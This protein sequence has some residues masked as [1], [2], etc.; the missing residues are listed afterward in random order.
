MNKILGHSLEFIEPTRLDERQAR[1]A[2]VVARVLS[3]ALS[4]GVQAGE[5]WGREVANRGKPKMNDDHDDEMET[6]G[7]TTVSHEQRSA[8]TERV[9]DNGHADRYITGTIIIICKP[10]PRSRSRSLAHV[11]FSYLSRGAFPPCRPARCL[12]MGLLFI[13]T[14]VVPVSTR[15][16]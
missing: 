11:S 8:L 16:P 7:R 15:H 3:R 9:P 2:D 10:P 5:T 4:K 12:E 1:L 6:S 14:R 13:E